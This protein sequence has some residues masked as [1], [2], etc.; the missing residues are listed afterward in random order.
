VNINIRKANYN[1]IDTLAQLY[2]DLNDYLEQHINYPGWRKG[3]YPT[4]EDALHFYESGTLYIAEIGAKMVGSVA[5]THEPEPEN[6]NWLICADDNEIFVIHILAA[7]PDFIRQGVG[8]ALLQFAETQAK[9]QNIK[10]IRLDVYEKNL[11]AI[12]AYEKS[13]YQFI[14]KVDIGLS[15]FGLDLFCLYEKVIL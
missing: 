2:D 15:E 7:H 6:E 11:P 3:G 4:K 13:G 12:N 14:D 1:D 5:L 10:S 9:L 8:S